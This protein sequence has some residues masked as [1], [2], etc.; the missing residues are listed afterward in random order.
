[1]AESIRLLGQGLF[2]QELAVGQLFRTLRRTIT[3]ADLIGF[4]GVTGQTEIL[5]IDATFEGAIKG[6]GRPIPSAL[7]YSM[8]EGLLMQTLLQNAGLALLE[9][10]QTIKAPVVIGDSIHGLVE[11]TEVRPTSKSGRA[12][13]ASRVSVVNQDEVLVMA[14]DVK[15]LIAGRPN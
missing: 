5:F 11:I 14:Y 12:V 7:T 3:E 6:E 9:V 1:V 13:V 8:I 15:R 10:S 4:I 2:W